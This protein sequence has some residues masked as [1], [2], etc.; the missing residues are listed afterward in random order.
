[1][2]LLSLIFLFATLFFQSCYLAPQNP[3]KD[4]Q[5]RQMR[6]INNIAPTANAN[7]NQ[8]F[9]KA[10]GIMTRTDMIPFDS[11]GPDGNAVGDT[12]YARCVDPDKAAK[13]QLYLNGHPNENVWFRMHLEHPKPWVPWYTVYV[14]DWWSRTLEEVQK[15]PEY[16]IADSLRGF[17]PRQVTKQQPSRKNY[18]PAPLPS[19]TETNSSD[20]KEGANFHYYQRSSDGSIIDFHVTESQ[21]KEQQSKDATPVDTAGKIPR[22]GATVPVPQ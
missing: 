1:M 8:L 2:K 3:Y 4:Q 16:V 18:T 13:L 12:L 10:L 6:A 19:R 14:I 11:Y 5:L 9:G 7:N 17:D 20:K 21:L 22:P 15:Q